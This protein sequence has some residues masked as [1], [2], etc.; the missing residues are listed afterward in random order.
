MPS[1][2][3]QSPELVIKYLSITWHSNQGILSHSFVAF[4]TY[5]VYGYDD[6][7]YVNSDESVLGPP[8]IYLAFVLEGQTKMVHLRSTKHHS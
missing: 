8:F 2:A 1:K 7:F 6:S 4:T 5:D 3:R